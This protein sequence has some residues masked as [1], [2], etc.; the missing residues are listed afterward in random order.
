MPSETCAEPG[1]GNELSK[2][3]AADPELQPY[4]QSHRR[5]K[6]RRKFLAAKGGAKA[7][8]KKAPVKAAP[9]AKP[10]PAARKVTLEDAVEAVALVEAIGWDVAR[11][12]AKAM[13]GKR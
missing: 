3:K 6:A 13:E 4:C 7:A 11:A 10:A 5:S 1:C 12:M 2:S 8:A 9:K